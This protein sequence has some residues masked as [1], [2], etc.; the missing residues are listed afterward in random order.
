[1]A[2]MARGWGWPVNSKKA[3]YFRSG[4]ERSLC[5][6]WAFWG[7]REDDS[8]SSPDNCAECKRRRAKLDAEEG[9]NGRP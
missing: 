2:D 6:Q 1:M 8:H 7:Q 9:G 4:S 3:H 5:G